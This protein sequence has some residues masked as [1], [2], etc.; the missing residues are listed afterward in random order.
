MSHNQTIGNKGEDLA[1]AF[2]QDIGYTILER[3]WRFARSE[4]DIIAYKKP[5]LHIVEVKTRTAH[6]F[7]LPEQSINKKKFKE[8]QSAAEA[9]LEKYPQYKML[10]FD[11]LAISIINNKPIEYFFIE[12]YFLQ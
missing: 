1:A 7:G 4:V 5:I 12:D 3:N 9:Y 6:H 2:L 11:I 8:L 10:Q